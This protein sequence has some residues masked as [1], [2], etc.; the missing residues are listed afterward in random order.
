VKGWGHYFL[1]KHIFSQRIQQLSRRNFNSQVFIYKFIIG[2]ENL[3]CSR[4]KPVNFS[5][6]FHSPD[7]AVL[8]LFRCYLQ[9]L[10]RLLDVHRDL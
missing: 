10:S 2:Y 9:H 5:K 6:R 7:L 4:H 3:K 1:S 8:T